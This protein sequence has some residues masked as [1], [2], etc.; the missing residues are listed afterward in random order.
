MQFFS[1]W[2]L[3]KTLLLQLFSPRTNQRPGWAALTNIRSN[4]CWVQPLHLSVI[5]GKANVL[6]RTRD[7][8]FLDFHAEK[9]QLAALLKDEAAALCVVSHERKIVPLKTYRKTDNTLSQSRPC[10]ARWEWSGCRCQTTSRRRRRGNTWFSHTATC[11]GERRG[12][13]RQR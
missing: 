3:I 9:N 13:V 2:L 8:H 5:K 11:V 10:L 12:C 4:S 7:Y 6:R 1:N